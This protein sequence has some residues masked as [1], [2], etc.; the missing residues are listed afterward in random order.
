MQLKNEQFHPAKSY[1]ITAEEQ[2]AYFKGVIAS[3][4]GLE[5]TELELS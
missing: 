2:K 3:L 5:D 4:K 1:I